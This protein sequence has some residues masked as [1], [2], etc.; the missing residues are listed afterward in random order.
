MCYLNLN[1][2]LPNENTFCKET[3]LYGRVSLHVWTDQ[4]RKT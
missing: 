1:R 4:E 3:L 2:H